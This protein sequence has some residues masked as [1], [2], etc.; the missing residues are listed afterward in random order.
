MP[1]SVGHI[2]QVHVSADGRLFANSLA[3]VDLGLIVATAAQ[4]VCP[5]W[6]KRQRPNRM[7]V[8]RLEIL[9]W[10]QVAIHCSEVPDLHSVIEST[11]DH[12]C[13][14]TIYAKRLHGLLVAV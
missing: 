13:S 11:S 2:E 14:F 12:L 7:S 5:A 10:L 8:E 6:I 3:I 1:F 9:K 4:E